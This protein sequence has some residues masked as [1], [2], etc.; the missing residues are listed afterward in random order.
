MW[1]SILAGL[2]ACSEVPNF[3]SAVFCLCLLYAT[4]SQGR[5]GIPVQTATSRKE[6]QVVDGTF[7]CSEILKVK[8]I[9]GA[10]MKLHVFLFLLYITELFC[11]VEGSPFLSPVVS[12]FP[13][14]LYILGN[15]KL[16]RPEA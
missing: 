15:L 12:N 6:T 9:M 16:Y 3:S 1:G 5:H 14:V 8:I 11:E 7:S 2:P 13:E 4:T 10:L